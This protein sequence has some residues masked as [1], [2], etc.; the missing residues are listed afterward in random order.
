MMT[1]LGNLFRKE[2]TTAFAFSLVPVVG[3]LSVHIELE[4]SLPCLS[5]GIGTEFNIL[6]GVNGRTVTWQRL[7][8]RTIVDIPPATIFCIGS[9]FLV[10]WLA[11]VS[12]MRN[13]GIGYS[14]P[15]PVNLDCKGLTFIPL[16]TV[17][18][19]AKFLERYLHLVVLFWEKV[20]PYR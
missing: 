19:I 4:V 5:S 12:A 17:W 15:F 18:Q 13:K 6:R 9:H 11:F 1:V 14:K 8:F 20:F 7:V 10:K 16:M 3:V 2:P